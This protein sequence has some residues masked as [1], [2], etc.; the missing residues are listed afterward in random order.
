MLNR[1]ASSFTR[2]K[3]MSVYQIVAIVVGL[4]IVGYGLFMATNF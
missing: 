2:E 3:L 4:V 1:T